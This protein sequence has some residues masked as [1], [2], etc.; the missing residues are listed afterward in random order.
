[1]FQIKVRPQQSY[2]FT[3]AWILFSIFKNGW[4]ANSF[5]KANGALG[6]NLGSDD[7]SLWKRGRSGGEKVRGNTLLVS[8]HQLKP[9]RGRGRW[10]AGLHMPRKEGTPVQVEVPTPPL[11]LSPCPGPLTRA[12]GSPGCP[13][14]RAGKSQRVALHPGQRLLWPLQV[15]T[16]H[17]SPGLGPC[18][19]HVGPAW[20][21]P[22]GFGPPG[23]RRPA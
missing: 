22:P 4:R 3:S 7:A 15:P 16:R 20:A 9:R 1:M 10:R 14:P 21:Q 11:I 12:P 17:P 23:A 6:Y 13:K 5:L 19:L 2:N 18:L 8:G